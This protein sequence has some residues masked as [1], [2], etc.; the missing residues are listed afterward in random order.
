[1]KKVFVGIV[2]VFGVLLGSAYFLFSDSAA[3][4]SAQIAVSGMSCPACADKIQTMLEKLEGVSTAKV[5]VTEGRA[6]VEYDPTL[7]TVAAMES[8][9]SKLGFGT[10]NFKAKSCAPEEK[11][12]ETE[13][14][15]G[16]G[17]DCC[18]PPAKRSDT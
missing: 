15:S 8:E 2:A 18:A 3:V 11:Q 12:C 1:M 10:A 16:V 9:I 6:H 7:I 14:P 17:T 4:S 5:S 13:K